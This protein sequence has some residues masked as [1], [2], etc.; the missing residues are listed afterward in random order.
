MILK[1]LPVNMQINFEST[2]R[3]M[4]QF[5]NS[6]EFQGNVQDAFTDQLVCISLEKKIT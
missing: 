1:D 2:D 6:A 4:E 3:L 5:E